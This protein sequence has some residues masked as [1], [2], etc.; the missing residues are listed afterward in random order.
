MKNVRLCLLITHLTLLLAQPKSPE[1]IFGFRIGDDYKLADYS[2]MVD[3]H[4]QLATTSDRVILQEIGKTA[5]GRPMLLQF[6]STPENL[7]HL[8]RWKSISTKLARARISENEARNLVKEGKSILW[9]DGG[10]HATERAHGQMTAEL[11]YRIATEES[12]EMKKIR[13]NV[14]VLLMPVMNPDG[15]DIVVDWYRRNL[16]TPFE[17]T[18]PPWLYHHYVGHDNNRDWFMNNMPESQACSRVIYNEWYPQIVYNH[19]QTGPSWA[20]IFLPPFSDP[21]NPNIHPGVTTGVSLVGTAMGNRFA[22][23]KMGG[24]VSDFQYSMWWNGGMRTAPYFHNQIGILTETSHSTPTPRFYDPDSIP[25]AIGSRRANRLANDGTDIF[26]PIPWEAG[27]SHFRDAVDYML[28]ASMAVLNVSADL[29]EKWLMNIYQMGRDAIEAGEAGGPFAYVIPTEQWDP[30]E[31]VNLATHLRR[32]GIEVHKSTEKFRAGDKQYPK[33]SYVIY[34]AQ[35]FRPMVLDMMEPQKYPNRRGPDGSPQVP[36]DLAGWTL[37]MQMGVT[38]DRIDKSFKAKAEEINHIEISPPPGEATGRGDW[39]YIVS[40]KTNATVIAANRLLDSGEKVS[41]LD[42]SHKIRSVEFGRG[43]IVIE[44]SGK[45]TDSAVGAMAADLGISFSRLSTK[46]SSRLI[47]AKQLRIGLYKSWVSNMDEGWT[48]WLLENYEFPMDT[49]HDADINGG[50]L[51]RYSAILIPDQSPARIL[52][53]HSMHTMPQEYVGGMGVEGAAALKQYVEDGGTL[54]MLDGASD[55]A[56]EQFGLPVRNAVSGISPQK[57]FIPG[58]LIKIHLNR[59]HPVTGGMQDQAAA[60]YVRSRAFKEIKLSRKGEGGRE[61][62]KV[63]PLPPV[64]VIATYAKEDILMS[65]WA[66]G[67]KNYIGGKAA[68]VRVTMG[69]G[70]IVL[71]GFRPQFRGQPRGTYKLLFNS[72][73]LSGLDSY[74]SVSN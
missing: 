61:D 65:G 66:L 28:T 37:P 50:R 10:M 26:L 34:A 17:T 5:L 57:F 46:P 41:Y 69:E 72:L 48:R 51:S 8:D 11:A 14:I 70:D 6:I 68:A 59:N 63:A 24:V 19:H 4:R 25:K 55:F 32:T 35:A 71:I 45:S 60:Y 47:P 52:N 16:G 13:E 1:E 53:G 67:E 54:I 18:S 30:V 64:E 44:S 29:R 33:G 62:T 20:R 3:Y 9:I 42:D 39:G 27:E 73:L 23:K 21:V 22:M 38:V 31:A 36:Y 58:S 56:I 12:E 7:R 74:P 15:M 43:A 49:L 2:Q 40:N